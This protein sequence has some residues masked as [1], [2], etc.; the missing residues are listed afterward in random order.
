MFYLVWAKVYGGGVCVW[1][2]GG[3]EGGGLQHLFTVDFTI[4]SASTTFIKYFNVA[5][6]LETTTKIKFGLQVYC[7]NNHTNLWTEYVNHRYWHN[8]QSIRFSMYWIIK[9]CKYKYVNLYLPKMAES[10]FLSFHKPSHYKTQHGSITTHSIQRAKCP[11]DHLV[12]Q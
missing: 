6:E 10:L 11:L 1:G 3:G 9:I 5:F 12:V 4:G 8:I 7:T 2:G